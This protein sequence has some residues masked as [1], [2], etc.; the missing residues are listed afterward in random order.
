M[1]YVHSVT[2][3]GAIFCH[4]KTLLAEI[5]CGDAPID[6][7]KYGIVLSPATRRV[8]EPLPSTVFHTNLPSNTT[9]SKE[10]ASLSLKRFLH[11]S[12][13]QGGEP[14]VTIKLLSS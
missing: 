5:W 7:D 3:K 6:T 13:M 2:A 8:R 11:L 10:M 4:H 9:R 1:L 14:R 12:Y